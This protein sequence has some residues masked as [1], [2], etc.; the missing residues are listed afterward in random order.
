MVDL[1]G[2]VVDRVVANRDSGRRQPAAGDQGHRH[3]RVEH[4][5]DVGAPRPG[6]DQGKREVGA[7][8]LVHLDQHPVRAAASVS[9]TATKMRASCQR[10]PAGGGAGG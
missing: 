1:L 3:G 8:E 9:P 7:A 5:P 6:G 2:V 4:D 10:P